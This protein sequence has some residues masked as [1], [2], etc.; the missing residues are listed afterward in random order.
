[1]ECHGLGGGSDVDAQT[2]Y[3][4][5]CH[6]DVGGIAS[7]CDQKHDVLLTEEAVVLSGLVVVAAVVVV[8]VVVVAVAAAAAAASSNPRRICNSSNRR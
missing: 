2:H 3:G 5:E 8:A 6:E 1:M 4:V 7:D